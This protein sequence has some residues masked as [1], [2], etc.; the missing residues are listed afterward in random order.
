[1][2]LAKDALAVHRRF[3]GD[4]TG[5]IALLFALSLFPLTLAA[6]MAI[7]YAKASNSKSILTSSLDAAV[8]S[9]AKDTNLKTDDAVNAHI[10]EMLK[11][12]RAT[13]ALSSHSVKSLPP[14]TSQRVRV[15]AE[16]CIKTLFGGVVGFKEMCFGS[17]AEA[18]RPGKTYFEIALVLD[19]SGSMNGYKI[20]TAREVAKNFVTQL[21]SSA[22]ASEP[23]QIKISIVPYE[24]T[25]NAG[26]EYAS[27]AWVDTSGQSSIHWENTRKPS[28]ANSRF[29]LFKE[30]GVPWNGC[31]ETR[32]G[33]FAVTDGEAHPTHADSLF[34][35]MFAPDEPGELGKNHYYETTGNHHAGGKGHSVL[36][37]YLNDDG[38]SK[39]H[40]SGHNETSADDAN[41]DLSIYAN[42]DWHTRQKEN[43]CRYRVGANK[44]RIKLAG[45]NGSS[46]GPNYM[47]NTRKLTRLSSDKTNLIT[48]IEAMKAGGGTNTLEGFLWGW[49]TL[50][51]N[52][53]FAD[54]RSYNWRK[55]AIT[56]RKVMIVMTD[57][58]NDGNY[59]NN[60][61][62]SRYSP[63]G[64]HTNKRFG[65]NFT[66]EAEAIKGVD[67]ALNAAC[68]NAKSTKDADGNEGIQ[69]YTI[70]F[71]TPG[72]EISEAGLKVL[73]D[74]ASVEAGKKLYYKA[75]SASELTKSFTEIIARLGTMRLTY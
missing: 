16:G 40:Y 11:A 51:P 72:A 10:R 17:T 4:D 12:N 33:A 14:S 6:G 48:N 20:D 26:P 28:W 54:G 53:P 47:C 41:C 23:D 29:D 42:H 70:G 1:M 38:S 3:A 75:T 44:K 50:S 2:K 58:D 45:T 32:P 65:T 57:G 39:V 52:T 55:D 9:A 67:N 46:L 56:N 35:P 74:C 34:V 25:V 69:I 73:M 19:N 60:P 21:L 5:S 68:K 24:L 59:H 18:E 66:S 27:A 30:L 63:F 15:N 22:S 49:R 31:F 7:D 13:D 8:L 37:S 61:N 36:N 71:S 64:Y 62:N 43:T